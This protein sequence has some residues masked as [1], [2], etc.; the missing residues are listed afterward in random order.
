MP[1]GHGVD[2][3][4]H[5]VEYL[6]CLMPS[7]PP[8]LATLV[9]ERHALL[10]L[11]IWEP[12]MRGNKR[13]GVTLSAFFPSDR[14]SLKLSLPRPLPIGSLLTLRSN[15]TE[16][17]KGCKSRPFVLTAG[18]GIAPSFLGCLSAYLKQKMPDN[19]PG[20]AFLFSPLTA[21]RR[22]FKDSCTSTS[23]IWESMRHHYEQA[24]LHAGEGHHGFRRGQ[25]KALSAAGMSCRH[26]QEGPNQYNS[27]WREVSRSFQAP[28][29]TR[30]ISQ[31]QKPACIDMM[32]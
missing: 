9:V 6:K 14:Q 11:F 27:N 3:V 30:T 2:K 25:M 8:T 16:T 20:S 1:I 23:D 7:S 26:R 24:A 12:S 31:S 18:H 28:A 19:A 32:W 5:L 15:G 29:V 13:G 22:Q 10:A 21:D 4:H 17:V